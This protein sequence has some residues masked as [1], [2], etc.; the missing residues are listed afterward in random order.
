MQD[1]DDLYDIEKTTFEK[2]Q[3]LA[4]DAAAAINRINVC[5]D[6]INQ[7]C[8]DNG[9]EPPAESKMYHGDEFLV[10]FL[11]KL[12]NKAD[13]AFKKSM[14]QVKNTIKDKKVR[15]EYLSD[16]SYENDLSYTLKF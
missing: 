8:K 9:I 7:Y 13:T 14:Q 3:I 2:C 6:A 4:G 16:A 5:Q 10:D 1:T 12:K 15:N 11:Q